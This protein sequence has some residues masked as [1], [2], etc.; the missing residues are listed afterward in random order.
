MQLEDDQQKLN[1][2]YRKE[3]SQKES[4]F[5]MNEKLNKALK[6]ANLKIQE[7][8]DKYKQKISK[9]CYYCNNDIDLSMGLN[10]TFD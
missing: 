10:G 8:K 9:K 2:K 3:Q 7:V 5:S 6:R 1:D 4:L